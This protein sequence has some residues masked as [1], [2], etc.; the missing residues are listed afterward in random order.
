MRV[1][2]KQKYWITQNRLNRGRTRN[3][4]VLNKLS[5]QKEINKLH[6]DPVNLVRALK[7]KDRLS[8]LAT[9]QSNIDFSKGFLDVTESAI[10]NMHEK[11][12]RAQELAIAMAND[13][14]DDKNRMITAKEVKEI[15]KE[16]VQMA[17]SKYGSRYIF[18]G[19][20]SLN[21]PVSLDGDFLGDDGKV[22]IQ[23]SP[24]HYKSINIS[25]RELLQP[26]KAEAKAGHA[27]LMD[28]IK[29]LIKGL[30]GDSK[31][32]IFRSVDEIAFQMDKLASFQASVGAIWTAVDEAGSRN[33]FEI[34]QKTAKLSDIEDA[35]I[36][37]TSSDFKRTESVL[38]STLMASNKLLQPSLLNFMQ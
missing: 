12:G 36:F 38:Q 35:D 15:L 6:D 29:L 2:E 31:E 37:K 5:T 19:F 17:N 9:Y 3:V 24:D 26:T 25:G 33:E 27:G 21:P 14:Y 20:R 1:S 10:A 13:S 28:S 18:A 11:L 34:L 32:A 7:I 4:E 30:E 23:V 22:F 16:M 8:A